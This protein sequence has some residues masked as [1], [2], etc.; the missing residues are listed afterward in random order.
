M[1]SSEYCEI[2]KNIYFEEQLRMTASTRLEFFFLIEINAFFI[3]S[4]FISNARL[5]MAKDLKIIHILHP[6]YHPKIMEHILKNK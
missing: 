6:R 1:F 5:K 3:G 4:N 2:F